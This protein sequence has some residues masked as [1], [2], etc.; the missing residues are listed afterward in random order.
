MSSKRW[1]MASVWE[2]PTVALLRC[3]CLV[4]ATA[5]CWS[6]AGFRDCNSEHFPCQAHPRRLPSIAKVMTYSNVGLYAAYSNARDATKSAS[7][8]RLTVFVHRATNITNPLL[9]THGLKNAGR[10]SGEKFVQA[11]HKA[12]HNDQ[13]KVMNKRSLPTI[14]PKLGGP[15]Y[16]IPS[17]MRS[18]TTACSQMK[19][20][21]T[22]AKVLNRPKAN[23]DIV[24]HIKT[25]TKA[26]HVRYARQAGNMLGTLGCLQ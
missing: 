23:A 17:T 1:P 8:T 9:P 18:T 21:A 19:S 12:A 22:T 15:T 16:A 11:S 10:S 25:V 13:A 14:G 2:Q 5:W 6:R 26:Q 7:C 24:S 3:G 4:C 20:M